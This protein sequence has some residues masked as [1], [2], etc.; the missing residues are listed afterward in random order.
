[1][2]HLILLFVATLAV[3]LPAPAQHQPIAAIPAMH[4]AVLQ[5]TVAELTV[6]DIDD[7]FAFDCDECKASVEIAFRDYG[8]FA[9]WTNAPTLTVPGSS[10]PLNMGGIVVNITMLVK[11]DSNGDGED[12][13]FTEN[14]TCIPDQENYNC[15]D[16]T[17]CQ[18]GVYLDL[19]TPLHDIIVGDPIYYNGDQYGG[20]V[21]QITK[22]SSPT[23][24]THHTLST[25]DPELDAFRP[26]IE[27]RVTLGCGDCEKIFD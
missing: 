26:Q 15:D 25:Y 20:Q 9:P 1:M 27:L 10:V 12:D 5:P 16:L 13:K 11:F 21:H 4:R 8:S 3:A 23:R 18:V 14:G 2:R 22:C 19:M 7:L 17:D 24:V 6:G